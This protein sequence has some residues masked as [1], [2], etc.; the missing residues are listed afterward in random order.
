MNINIPDFTKFT[1]GLIIS[2]ISV[3]FSIFALIYNVDYIFYGFF[4]FVF[5]ILT[6]INGVC[7]DYLINGYKHKMKVYVGIELLLVIAWLLLAII[8]L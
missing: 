1:W 5:G 4:T 3:V 6:H 7:H 8:V 2:F